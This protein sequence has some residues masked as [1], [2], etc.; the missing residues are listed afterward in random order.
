MV[1]VAWYFGWS[2]YSSKHTLLCLT[3][4]GA[5]IASSFMNLALTIATYEMRVSLFNYLPGI[6]KKIP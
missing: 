3:S 4:I 2:S 1:D 6:Y 5:A